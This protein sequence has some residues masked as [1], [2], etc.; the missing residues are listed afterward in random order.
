LSRRCV[1]LVMRLTR[2]TGMRSLRGSLSLTFDSYATR[3]AREQS[4]PDPSSLARIA[5]S[6][7]PGLIL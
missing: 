4:W 3:D 2:P 1:T 5:G 6:A 7:G